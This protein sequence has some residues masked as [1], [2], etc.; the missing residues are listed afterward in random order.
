MGAVSVRPRTTAHE[1]ATKIAK[2]TDRQPLNKYRVRY[3]IIGGPPAVLLPSRTQEEVVISD[4]NGL[5]Y[6]LAFWGTKAS[7]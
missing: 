5:A 3:K 4:L 2:F 6:W 7:E 1:F